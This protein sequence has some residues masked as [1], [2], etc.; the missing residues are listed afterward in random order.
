MSN[1]PDE[2]ENSQVA[3]HQAQDTATKSASVMEQISIL[4]VFA[5]LMAL[6]VSSAY[7]IFLIP[8][9]RIVARETADGIIFARPWGPLYMS[10]PLLCT[11]IASLSAGSFA[12]ARFSRLHT[13]A[14]ACGGLIYIPIFASL[15]LYIGE[16]LNSFDIR[17]AD[18]GPIAVILG[19]WL[20]LVGYAVKSFYDEARDKIA[21]WI[22]RRIY[23]ETDRDCP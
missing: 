14:L 5:I 21:E 18:N 9:C 4:A 23:K 1:D 16:G 17:R 10:I 20:L 12:R 7:L 19:F 3:I 15:S 6:T 11:G 8:Q 2:H 13:S 22:N